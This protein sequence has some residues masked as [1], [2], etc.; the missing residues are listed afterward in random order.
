MKRSLLI[1]ILTLLILSPGCQGLSQIRDP[2][3]TA[4][5]DNVPERT[6]LTVED[7]M[8]GFPFSGP[9]QEGALTL[10]VNADP[11]LH[12]FEGRLVLIGESENGEW[13]IYSESPLE[14][15]NKH[16]PQFD[17]EFVQQVDHLVP[18]K[19]GQ[20]IT[21]HPSWN[22][23]L[24]PGRAWSEPGDAGYSRASFPFALTW[25]GSNAV[26]NGTMTFLYN[27]QD[28]SRV[29][30][31]VTQETTIST[32]LDMWGLL[33]AEYHPD[34]VTNSDKIKSAFLSE[35]NGRFPSK[36]IEALGEDYPGVDLTAFAAG[37]SPDHLA[38]YGFVIN[39]VQY[40]GGCQTRYGI[41]PYCESMRVPSYSTAKSA[42]ASLALMRLG[43]KYD[44]AVPQFLIKDYLPEAAD[45][46][47]DWE[48]VTFNDT[49]D[50]ATG[51][52]RTSQ[53]MVD[54]EQWDGTDPFWTEEYYSERIQ[55]AFNWP[56]SAVPGSTWV[57]RTSDT[58]ILSAAMQNYLKTEEGDQADIFQFVVDEV[59][60]PLGLGPGVYSSVRT[61]DNNWAGLPVGGSGLF[62][63]PDDLAKISMFLNVDHG[64]INGKQIL[65]PGQLDAVLQKDPDDRGVR[66]DG[67]GRYNNAFWADEY[68]SQDG[69]CHFWVPHMYGYSGIVV[70]L[71]PNGTAYYYASD[72]QEFT[73]TRAI[74]ES[75][76]L[77]P[78]CG[79]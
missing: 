67:D 21:D 20:I 52:F 63:V 7:L 65:D 18:V 55:A 64:R 45:S 16:L 23:H 77:I 78:V 54:E 74:Q 41:Y 9:V 50:M 31:Q 10:P 15:E 43:Q 51:N 72:N 37:V 56:N 61:R 47:G 32:T 5:I 36:P 25:K 68:T 70:A 71:L 30:Y 6:L 29:W 2:N 19:R 58:F 11:A 73:T 40:L 33:R 76:K 3:N 26:L 49:L 62:W 44:A 39:G 35:L 79:E 46:P 28:I 8:D 34:Q 17:F 59:Y 66:R 4:A 42:F 1:V 38:W 14:P 69:T 75:D 22:L 57:Y 13:H 12:I 60:Q 53:R 27:D 24:E 48:S